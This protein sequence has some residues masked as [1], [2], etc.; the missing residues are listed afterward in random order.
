[1]ISQHR[2]GCETPEPQQFP[3]TV[4]MKEEQVKTTV[5][6]KGLDVCI[7]VAFSLDEF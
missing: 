1:M 7:Y 4:T 6:V 5:D 3:C 2:G